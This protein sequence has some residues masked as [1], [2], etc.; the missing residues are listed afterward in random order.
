MKRFVVMTMAGMK[1]GIPLNWHYTS[2]WLVYPWT[3]YRIRY[4]NDNDNGD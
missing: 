3:S 4:D 2:W 1:W